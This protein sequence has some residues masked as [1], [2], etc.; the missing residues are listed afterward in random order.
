VPAPPIDL[1]TARI[2]LRSQLRVLCNDLILDMDKRGLMAP[3]WGARLERAGFKLNDSPFDDP[4][5]EPITNEILY[6]LRLSD[7]PPNS[8]YPGFNG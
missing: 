7:E 1:E 2:I 3:D 6:L 4:Y 8:N 5:L